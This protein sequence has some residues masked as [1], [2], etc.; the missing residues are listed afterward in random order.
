MKEEPS[1]DTIRDELDRVDRALFDLI[2]ERMRLVAEVRKA[3]RFSGKHFF[4]RSR[5]RAVFRRAEDIGAELGLPRPVVREVMAVLI[6]ASHTLQE[7]DEE[8][9][10]ESA[11]ARASE[12]TRRVLIVGGRGKMGRLFE[13]A[14]RRRA[15]P[16][17]VL[18]KGEPLD[19]PRVE[20][21][22]IVMLAVPM[23]EAESV[24]AALGPR[25]RSDALL[26]D[27]NSLKKGVCAALAE[28]G[29]GESV[30][31]HPMFG[32]TVRSFRRQ[33]IV[34]CPVAPGP[35]VGWL[36]SELGRMGAELI[37]TDA[38]THDRMMGIVQVMTHFGTM[39]MGRALSESGL[40][41]E[42]TLAF[43]ESHLPSRGLDGGAALL[44]KPRA[45]R[46]NPF[47]GTVRERFVEQ[48]IR[49]STI[50]SEEDRLA[51]ADYFQDTARYFSD[52][53]E[54]AMI[55]SDEIIEKIMSR[56]ERSTLPQMARPGLRFSS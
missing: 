46:G 32:P 16:V 45:L 29:A 2:K 17:D 53:S 4:D 49:L 5:E 54:E 20:R 14:F 22:D 21:A 8:L 19:A 50:L 3:K 9:E 47:S 34:I 55:L 51:F 15:H 1:L 36:E 48:A 44:T 28:H 38:E 37:R 40:S 56:P 39:V 24:T 27:I 12:E 33:K 43:H 52:F 35:M 13:K 10:T 42:E 31:M 6:E 18:E 30:G 11:S 23:A 41:L 7:E 25:V 26:C